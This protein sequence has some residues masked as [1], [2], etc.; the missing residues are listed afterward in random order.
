M[1]KLLIVSFFVSIQSFAQT[2]PV[3]I[4]FDVTSADTLV[5]KA[6]IRHVSTMAEV[7][8]RSLFEVVVYGSALPMLMKE[9]SCVAT[10]IRKLESR[11]NVAI[12]VCELSLKGSKVDKS[13]LFGNIETVPDGILE[14]AIKQ[15]KG[16][17]Y[18]KESR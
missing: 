11:Q 2:R 12:K 7:Y 15:A 16:W 18:I 6:V 10:G 14:I 4:V 13:Q 1:K 5:H 3:K 9:K 17:R 8:P